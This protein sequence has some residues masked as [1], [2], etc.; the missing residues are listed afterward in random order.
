MD[1]CYPKNVTNRPVVVFF[2]GGGLTEGEKYLPGLYRQNG[3]IEVAPNYRLSPKAK[4]PAYIEDAAEAVS[5]VWNNIERYGGDKH[6]IIITGNSAGAYLTAMLAMDS[7]YLLKYGI[8]P[9]D[10]WIYF[11]ESA[12]MTTHFNILRERGIS[13]GSNTTIVDEYAPSYYKRKVK[14]V[15]ILATGDRNLDMAGR[16]EQNTTFCNN[17]KELGCNIIYWEF[18]DQTHNSV[19]FV[20]R[21]KFV[22]LLRDQS[23][24]QLFPK[25]TYVTDVFFENEKGTLYSV[26]GVKIKDNPSF[27]DLKIGV[28][29]IYRNKSNKAIKIGRL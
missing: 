4:C 11:T 13:A 16:Y 21:T 25:I 20:A 19:G 23:L 15:F 8:H 1:I 10:I 5:W 14:S 22:G 7:T 3:Y 28:I 6:K 17:L 12:Q 26:L 29:Y 9:D 2:H 18:P 24:W 27:S